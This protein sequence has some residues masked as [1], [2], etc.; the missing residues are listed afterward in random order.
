MLQST[1]ID[2]L[3][4][5][6]NAYQAGKKTLSAPASKFCIALAQILKKHRLLS[7][8]SV[9]GETKKT[10]NL[11]LTYLNNSPAIETLKIFSKPGRRWYEKSSSLPW[12]SSHQTLIIISTSQGL[13]S[14]RQAVK[15]KLGGEVIA[16]IN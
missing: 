15:Q 7:D 16:Q 9:S 5:I 13:L 10:I 14:Q 3:I 2:F 4:R 8:Y 11:Q 1:S 6:K 12:G